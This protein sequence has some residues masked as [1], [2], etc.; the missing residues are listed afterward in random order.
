MFF[1]AVN[2]INDDQSMEEIRC[3]LDKPRIAPYKN[4]WRPH[5]NKVYWCSLKLAQKK[6]LQFYQTRSHA[7]VLYNTLPVTCIEK[8][9]CM[10][11]KEELYHKVC[12]SPRLPRIVL[13]PNSQS[14]QQDQPDQDARKSSDHQSASGSYGKPAAATLTFE[15]Q[16]Y[17]STTTHES[18]R[19]GQKVDS[20][21][22]EPPEQEFFLQDLNKTEEIDTFSEKSKKVDHRTWAIRR[23]S[24][25]A[26]HL[27]RNNAPIVHYIG[28]LALYTGHVGTCPIPSQSTKKLDKKNCDTLLI[29]GYVIQK[30]ITRGAKHGASERQRMYYKA[31]EMLQKARQPKHGGYKTILERWHNDDKLPRVFVKNWVDRRTA[32][33]V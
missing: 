19:N 24:S 8:A 31:K 4:T 33:S 6:G 25:F 3:D 5:Q 22:R 11:T 13:K 17:L 14:G 7:T 2:P 26:K 27:P 32:Y 28:K 16:A 21:V 9:V 15:Y 29:P 30:N 23:S 10:K 1:A 12:Q 20:A 18:Q